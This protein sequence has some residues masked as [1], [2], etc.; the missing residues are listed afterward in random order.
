MGALKGKAIDRFVAKRDPSISAVLIYGPD[1]GLVRER[2]DTL[3]KSVTPDFKDPFNYIDL[4]D[5]DI[6]TEP[7]R[8]ADEAAALSFS[9]GERVVRIRTAGD[10]AAGAAKVLVDGLDGG[11]IKSNALVIIEAGELTKAAKI[12]KLFEAAKFAAAIPCYEDTPEDVKSLATQRAAEEGLSF[13]M[14]LWN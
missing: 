12:R 3:A 8:L 11:S 5:A 13:E 7:S 1:A 2:A 4:T 14:T 10:G 9:G 6:K